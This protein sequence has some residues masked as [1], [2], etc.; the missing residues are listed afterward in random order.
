MVKRL[1]FLEIAVILLVFLLIL[2][3]FYYKINSLRGVNFF[4]AISVLLTVVLI[5]LSAVN[6]YTTH[7]QYT[8]ANKPII[9]GIM[10]KDRT[11]TYL[12][13]AIINK[14]PGVAIDIKWVLKVDNLGPNIYVN[15]INEIKKISIIP[16]T[17]DDLSV[18]SN[19]LYA[20]SRDDRS[21]T[22]K[23]YI[24]PIGKGCNMSQSKYILF[25][26]YKKLMDNNNYFCSKIVFSSGGYKCSHDDLSDCSEF[27]DASKEN[28]SWE[29]NVKAFND[30]QTP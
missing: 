12:D 24:P 5:L 14:G 15:V 10:N 25:L 19:N 1:M 27:D 11:N 16:N 13:L 8:M 22:L 23:G 3:L 6:A 29:E 7:L 4:T 28:K 2:T 21:V 26:K 17:V 9:D 30:K 20:L 18:F